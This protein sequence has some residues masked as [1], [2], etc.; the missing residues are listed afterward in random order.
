MN[1]KSFF[2]SWLATANKVNK[3]EAF[4]GGKK[5]VFIGQ[6]TDNVSPTHEAQLDGAHVGIRFTGMAEFIQL[7]SGDSHSV[8]RFL[9]D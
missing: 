5:I 2:Q 6:S 3:I 8:N 7:D 1:V 9:N 4:Q